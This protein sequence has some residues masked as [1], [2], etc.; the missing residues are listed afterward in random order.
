V[1]ACGHPQVLVAPDTGTHAGLTPGQSGALTPPFGVAIDP[2]FPLTTVDLTLRVTGSNG[3]DQVFDLTLP[4]GGF[5]EP[6]EG[7]AGEWTH[8]VVT[9]GFAD[10]WH[11]STERNHTPGGTRSW[12]CGD[13]GTGTYANR[14]DAA[15]V[16]PAV[17]LAGEGRLTFWQW[18]DAEVSQSYPGKAYDG[19]LVEI[20]VDGGAFSQITPV[21]G[22]PYTIRTGGTP[23][24]F[25]ADTPVFSGTQNWHAVTFDLAGV[26]GSVVFRWRF[27][28]DGADAMEGWHVDDVEIMGTGNPA[29]AR[30]L[31]LLPT[32]V[33]LA[34]VSP[35]PFRAGTQVRFALPRDA[36]VELRVFDAAG[37][38]VR[39]LL[40][41]RLP[42][43]PHALAWAGD[44]D[45]GRRVA[46]GQYYC[47]LRTPEATRQRGV[48]LLK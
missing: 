20:S 6:V 38:L 42:A 40:D 25:P 5:F 17:E 13:S 47:R 35:N 31:I 39:T 19:G 33:T 15:L 43:G 36:K 1:L 8:Y 21:G 45:A 11:V 10:Q 44:D 37:R 41:G 27:G 34:P 9:A 29:D 26:T 28:T 14:M 4:V 2:T 30:D 46:S 12:K 32:Q 22:Y 18:I 3:Y 16:S 7:G 24:P 48:V 23:G